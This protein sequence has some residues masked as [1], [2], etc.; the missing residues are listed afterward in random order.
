[1]TPTTNA[2]G[3]NKDKEG[4]VD[5]R[6]GADYVHDILGNTEVEFEL[7]AR[8]IQG[9]QRMPQHNLNMTEAIP[10]SQNSPRPNRDTEVPNEL[11]SFA[12]LNNELRF[13]RRTFNTENIESYFVDPM[14]EHDNE[15][16]IDRL[17]TEREN[18]ELM[19]SGTLM[20]HMLE[21]KRIVVRVIFHTFV[22]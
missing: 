21:N 15:N 9:I 3:I 4:L 18:N 12:N 5:P 20:N 2:I 17:P 22:F 16:F 7:N 10:Q 1:M 8:S 13:N 6:Y 11:T 19:N 14:N